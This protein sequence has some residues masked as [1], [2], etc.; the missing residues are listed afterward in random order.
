MTK[1]DNRA[2]L[3]AVINEAKSTRPVRV[4]LKPISSNFAQ[5]YPPD[6]EGRAWWARLKSALGTAS[7]DFVNASLVQL[8]GAARLPCSGISQTALNAALALIEG[9]KPRNELEAALVMQMACTHAANM[10]V[11]GRFQGGAGGERR[12]VAMANA[13]ARLSQAFATQMEALRRL[14]NGGSQFVRVEH[15]HVSE[16]GQ[17]IIGN[18]RQA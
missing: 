18:V 17:A 16:G 7:S 15:V 3:P 6:G 9:A 13:S 14:R 1:A 11:L 4:K 2:P 10:I 8:Q 12:V 5:A